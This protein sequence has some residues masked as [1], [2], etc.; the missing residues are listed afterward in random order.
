MI[1]RI[2]TVTTAR[3]VLRAPRMDDFDAFAA[4]R[5]SERTRHVGGP[6]SRAEAF[7]MFCALLG[8][9]PLRGYGRWLVADRVTDEPLG[10]VGP[11]YPEGWPEPE[12]AWS[13]FD[14]G[15][16]RGIAHEAALAARDWAARE[17]GWQTPASLVA[18]DNHRSAA[19]A[20]RLGAV[21]DGLHIHPVYGDLVIWRHPAPVGAAMTV[22]AGT[23]LQ[24]DGIGTVGERA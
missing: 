15:E 2:P 9:W 17:L 14:A 21:E 13:V 22:P 11:Y 1:D 24:N 12:I 3:L 4:F 6:N 10:I 16:G 19:L 5:A 18:R 8:H 23:K 7:A 20:R